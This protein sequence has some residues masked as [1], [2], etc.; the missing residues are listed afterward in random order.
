MKK[1]IITSILCGLLMLNANITILASENPDTS[2]TL[3][4]NNEIESV[5]IDPDGNV[6]VNRIDTPSIS[7]ID[8]QVIQQE[9]NPLLNNLAKAT[10][11]CTSTLKSY[12]SR[13]QL[14]ALSE[15]T[16]ALDHMFITCSAYYESGSLVGTA[17]DATPSGWTQQIISAIVNVPASP[18]PLEIASGYSYHLYRDSSINDVQHSLFWP[19]Q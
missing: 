17:T 14:W 15:A 16:T 1:R 18:F 8:E 3:T 12:N 11:T 6:F 10:I 5:L 19:K 2:T 4:S 7:V 13:T 9:F